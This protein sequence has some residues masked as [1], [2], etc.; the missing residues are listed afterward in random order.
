MK[1]KLIT[2]SSLVL[3]ALLITSNL[4][5]AGNEDRA[6]QAGASE[7][8]INPWAR[9]TGWGDANS[10]CVK[11]FEAI[12]S[13]VAGTAF[14]KQTDLVYSRSIYLKGTG[15]FINSG[16]LSQKVGETG[17]LSIALMSMSFGDID[18]TT[19]ALPEGGLG[20]YSPSYF[21]V[22]LAYAKEFS[23]SIY[24]GIV[25]KVVN[26]SISDLKATGVCFD[27][28]IQYVTGKRKQIH[29]GISLKNMGTTMK[30]KGDGLSF[31]SEGT[32]GVNMTVDS[33]SADFELPMMLKIGG[34]YDLKLQESHALTIAG[35]FTSNSFTKDQIHAGLEYSFKNI[36]FLRGGYIYE[37]GIGSYET[38]TT[39][40]TG[41]TA[42]LSVQVP[43]NKENGSSFSID[44][45]YR[46]TDP[47]EGTH[48]I[49][50]KVSL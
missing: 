23:N 34:A 40:Y 3:L 16:G 7:L 44:Y 42:G 2:I 1:S 39:A 43:I 22:A 32:N 27:A 17:V 26:E 48:N 18:V 47:F 29:F 49:G 36:L 41:P 6:G 35:T 14:T 38:R 31:R 50:V 37:K 30:F 9:S 25:V 15:I 13:N 11:G 45:S 24:G 28:G 4:L 33:R 10:S 20:T 8:L 12:F 19:C 5:Y 46:S 21:N